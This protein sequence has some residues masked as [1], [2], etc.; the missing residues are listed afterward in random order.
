[1]FMTRSCGNWT[2]GDIAIQLPE[3]LDPAN[4]AFPT[5]RDPRVLV[6]HCFNIAVTGAW[7]TDEIGH[8]PKPIF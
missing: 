6:D 7:V 8:V 4:P 3:L 2:I 5:V 1:M